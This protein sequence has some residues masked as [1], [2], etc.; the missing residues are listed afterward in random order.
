MLLYKYLSHHSGMLMI[1]NGTVGF[2]QPKYFNDPFELAASYPATTGLLDAIRRTAKIGIV[3]EN[4]GILSLTRQPLNPLMWAHY[5]DQ[6]TGMVIGI[7]CSI[8]EFTCK[9]TNLVP[10]Q[11]GNVI[12]TNTKPTSQYLSVHETPFPL[13]GTFNFSPEHLERLQRMFLFKPACWA[14]EEEVRVVKRIP[15][16]IDAENIQSGQLTALNDVKGN[17]LHIMKLPNSAIKE[18][19]IGARNE[20]MD[21]ENVLELI[22][23]IRTHQPGTNIY[24][25][26]LLSDKWELSYFDLVEAVEEVYCHA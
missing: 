7:D 15:N 9:A 23:N 3:A 10:I 8:P 4:A 13:G 16:K 22:N 11:Y 26:K 2:R 18:V 5:G 17:P 19:Y 24:G 25:C 6:H 14:Y 12:Y 20:H 1:E 21:D